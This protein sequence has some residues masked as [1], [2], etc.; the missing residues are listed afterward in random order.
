MVL[1]LKNINLKTFFKYESIGVD[2]SENLKVTTKKLIQEINKKEKYNKNPKNINMDFTEF[3]SYSENMEYLSKFL[4][5]KFLDEKQIETLKMNIDVPKIR[6]FIENDIFIYGENSKKYLLVH[7]IRKLQLEDIVNADIEFDEIAIAS[8]HILS[9]LLGDKSQTVKTIDENVGADEYMSEIINI[10]KTKKATEIYASLR[11][12]ELNIRI[13][14]HEGINPISIKGIKEAEILRKWFEIKTGSREGAI[15]YDGMFRITHDDFRV[16]FQETYA[17]YRITTRVYL[18]EFK[19]LNS[20]EEAGYTQKAEEIIKDI[21]LSQDGGLIFSAPTGQGKT[22]TQNILLTILANKGYEII[23]V[24]NPVEKFIS[25][26]DQ[27]DM[28]KYTD[29]EGIHKVTKANFINNAMRSKADV[30]GLGEIREEDFD[31]AK[32]VALTGHFFMGSTHT[33]SVLGTIQRFKEQGWS[34]LDIKT[35]LRGVVYQQLT[36]QLCP[37]CKI[38]DKNSSNYKSDEIAIDNSKTYYKANYVGCPNCL[39]GYKKIFTPIAEIA[40]FPIFKDFDLYNVKTYQN[41]ISFIQDAKTKF[42]L[43]IIDYVHFRALEKKERVP[44]FIDF[45]PKEILDKDIGDSD[46]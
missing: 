12:F 37:H 43:G 45:I 41:Y 38:E 22:T 6:S 35:L 14:N 2:E 13:R 30:I 32:K 20:L 40:Q 44:F 21:S 26:I 7:D 11:N 3:I 36:R 10:A 5:L 29:A 18:N 31:D 28:T 39:H 9:T 24:E 15:F 25:K 33:N 1:D 42:E 19:G 8:K 4:H 17:G 23:S 34:D 16:N 46:E 27:I